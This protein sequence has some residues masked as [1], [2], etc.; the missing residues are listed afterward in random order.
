MSTYNY[1]SVFGICRRVV[2]MFPKQPPAHVS[3]KQVLTV[4]AVQLYNRSEK[5]SIEVDLF[6][7]RVS[8]IT[9]LRLCYWFSRKVFMANLKTA[10]ALNFIQIC[11]DATF[12]IGE[13]NEFFLDFSRSCFCANYKIR[14]LSPSNVFFLLTGNHLQDNISNRTKVLVLLKPLSILLFEINQKNASAKTFGKLWNSFIQ[15]LGLSKTLMNTISEKFTPNNDHREIILQQKRF[16]VH[17]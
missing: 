4:L 10:C 11:A 6:I 12:C 3:L 7:A 16:T 15:G 5:T 8:E 14:F 2:W 13:K 1:L 9:N 17:H